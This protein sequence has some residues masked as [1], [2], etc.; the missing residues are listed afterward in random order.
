MYVLELMDLLGFVPG[1]DWRETNLVHARK[2]GEEGKYK[3]R[4][5][6]LIFVE[7]GDDVE[8]LWVG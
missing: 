2:E 8:R 1:D 4:P 3:R 6:E 7:E 5:D